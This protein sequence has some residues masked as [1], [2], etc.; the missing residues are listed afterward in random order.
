MHQYVGEDRLPGWMI[1]ADFDVPAL[2]VSLLDTRPT[3]RSGG[4]EITQRRRPTLAGGKSM[5]GSRLA[6][7]TSAQL[8]QSGL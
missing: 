4:T 1:R 7:A 3:R 2:G 8:I 5:S 6:T